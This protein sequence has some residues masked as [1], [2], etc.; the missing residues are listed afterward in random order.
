MNTFYKIVAKYYNR[1]SCIK[2][3]TTVKQAQKELR[4]MI[5]KKDKKLGSLILRIFEKKEKG[6]PKT[7]EETFSKDR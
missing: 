7:A 5:P 1:C 3:L 4:K 6:N 2:L